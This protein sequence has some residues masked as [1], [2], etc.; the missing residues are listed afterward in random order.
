MQ[1]YFRPLDDAEAWAMDCLRSGADFATYAQVYV[2]VLNLR[3]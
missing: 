1:T 2:N 3:R